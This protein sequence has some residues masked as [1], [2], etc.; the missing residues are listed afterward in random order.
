MVRGSTGTRIRAAEPSGA[1]SRG[2]PALT[3]PPLLLPASVYSF[4]VQDPTC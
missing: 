1:L 3:G 2:H 4:R